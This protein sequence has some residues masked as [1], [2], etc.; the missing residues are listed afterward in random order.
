LAR[1]FGWIPDARFGEQDVG[2]L[3]YLEQATSASAE[4]ADASAA[5]CSGRRC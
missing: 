4:V 5:S 2:W 1:R 3:G